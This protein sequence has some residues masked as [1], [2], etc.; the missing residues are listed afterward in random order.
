MQVKQCCCS[1]YN[2]NHPQCCS[3]SFLGASLISSA[4]SSCTSDVQR[5]RLSRRSCMIKVLSLYDSSPRVSN[6]AIASSKACSTGLQ[7]RSGEFRIS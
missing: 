5:V 4:P 6:S 1:W 2:G 7:A 3:S